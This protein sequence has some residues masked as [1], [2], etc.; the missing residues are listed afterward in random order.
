MTFVC[1]L[2]PLCRR[3]HRRRCRRRRH[4]CNK[5]RTWPDVSPRRTQI[6]HA[7]SRRCLFNRSRCI[8]LVRVCVCVCLQ[9]RRRRRRQ[10]NGSSGTTTGAF[11]Y[12]GY[13]SNDFLIY[14]HIQLN[15]LLCCGVCESASAGVCKTRMLRMFALR[16]QGGRFFGIGRVRVS[17]RLT[18]SAFACTCASRCARVW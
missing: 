1:S 16:R 18:A 6:A 4:R 8:Y 17:A 10:H 11:A 7:F 14:L 15:G 3:R 2:L 9:Q 12:D 13:K 5:R